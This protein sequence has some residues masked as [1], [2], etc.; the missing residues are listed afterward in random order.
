M[1]KRKIVLTASLLLLLTGCG[2]TSSGAP[3]DAE[4]LLDKAE[5][6]M[7]QLESVHSSIVFDESSVTSE[8]VARDSKK[9]HIQ[10]DAD[11]KDEKAKEEIVLQIPKQQPK[12]ISIIKEDGKLA[13]RSGEE[14]WEAMTEEQR[15]QMLDVWLPFTSPVMNLDLLKPFIEDAEIE[16]IDY[17]YA[18]Q[19]SLS[20]SDYRQFMKEV[21]VNSGKPEEFIHT[22]TGFPVIE[23]LDVELRINEKTFFVTGLKLSSN[24]TSYF[25]RDYIRYKQ[26]L[27][28]TYSYFNDIDPITIPEAAVSSME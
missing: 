9:I 2:R 14:D 15:V 5:R 21:A 25:D 12:D 1:N 19:F 16:K 17:G 23:K 20:P 3:A 22:H 26:K 11:L 13:V 27:D 8:P 18:L 10:A 24:V 4:D 28:A 7:G 6:A